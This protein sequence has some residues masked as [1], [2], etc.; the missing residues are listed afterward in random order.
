MGPA[1]L[2]FPRQLQL[3]CLRLCASNRRLFA[4]IPELSWIAGLLFEAASNQSAFLKI[5][6][7]AAREEFIGPETRAALAVYQADHGLAVTS[8]IDSSTLA[9]LGV[10]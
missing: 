4:Q 8:A 1:V 7:A 9:T 5:A 6:T 10:A 2:I 3:Y